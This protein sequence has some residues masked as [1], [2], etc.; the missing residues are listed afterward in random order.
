MVTHHL[1]EIPPGI[2]ARPAAPGGAVVAAGPVADTLTS[3]AVSDTFGVAVAS[4]TA[5]VDGGSPGR[6]RA[7]RNSVSNCSY[8]S[9][10]APALPDAQGPR[11][12]AGSVPAGKFH[13]C[14]ARRGSSRPPIQP[15]PLHDARR[16]PNQRKET[17]MRK[18]IMLVAA[19]LLVVAVAAS[20]AVAV[21]VRRRTLTW[22]ATRQA[23]CGAA[24]RRIRQYCRLQRHRRWLRVERRRQPEYMNAV[25]VDEYLRA[26]GAQV[27]G[28][29]IASL[30]AGEASRRQHP[31]GRAPRLL[32]PYPGDV[33]SCIRTGERRRLRGV[34]LGR[35]R[36]C[37]CVPVHAGYLEFDRGVVGRSDLV[38]VDPAQASP[39]D[40]DA[41]AQALYAEQGSAP[42]GGAC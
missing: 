10:A 19:P 23:P 27:V 33:L 38:G 17:H 6:T 2:T 11:T 3:E 26:L 22:S 31:D 21:P 35:V 7:L 30:M 32:H 14:S 18:R 9:S 16:G 25:Q 42:W 37:R 28:D 40:Q 1:E 12:P 5:S 15:L 36:R 4:S 8:A 34:Q 20:V 39:G 41:M 13:P 29:Y 24:D